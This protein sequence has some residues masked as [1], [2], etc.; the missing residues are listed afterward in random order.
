MYRGAAGAD[1]RKVAQLI[2][3]GKFGEPD[4]SRLELVTE[5]HKEMN[6]DLKEGRSQ[7]TALTRIFALRSFFAWADRSNRELTKDTAVAL[8]SAWTDWLV[9]RTRL[10]PPPD[11]QSR[12][13]GGP[14]DAI[15]I[16]ENSA[17]VQGSAVGMLL[18]C[19][20]GLGGSLIR[21]TRLI[22]LV[23]RKR[24]GI[25][26]IQAE[27]QNLENTMTFG[28]M[29]QDICDQL[30][31]A[32]VKKSVF[33]FQL[34]LR[35]GTAIPIPSGMIRKPLAEH[36]DIGVWHRLI[37]LRIE[38][39]LH[40]FIQQTGM[41]LQ[42]AYNLEL[43]HFSYQSYLDGYVV[44][45]RKARRGG[46]VVFQI[47]KEYRSHLSR[48]LAW[49]RELFPNSKRLFPFLCF[50]GRRE[51]AEFNGSRIREICK[52]FNISYIPP[53][54][55]RCTR[56]N[57][58]LR[59]SA[60]AE[61]TAEMVQHAEET[62]LRVYDR[63]SLQRA[64]AEVIQFWGKADPCIN[65]ELAAGPGGCVGK[66]VAS[67]SIP[68]LAPRPDCQKPS[69]CLWCKSHRDVDSQDYVW[70]LATFRYLKWLELSLSIRRLGQSE[71][72]PASAV[73]DQLTLKLRWF[74]QSSTK[75][76]KWFSE[77]IERIHE[78]NYHP[79]WHATIFALESLA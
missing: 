14:K 77:A 10:K 55:L 44:K 60:D 68:E 38:A 53:R 39:E 8:Y 3:E 64:T 40:M 30:T 13:K 61:L 46:E 57:W 71:E 74:E 25:I 1:R 69:G 36:G 28:H 15:Y 76:R 47:F 22:G 16:A 54:T 34:A 37:N 23:V 9:H 65:M 7:R 41:N 4:F 49:R 19:A 78:G 2:A 45:D 67:A 50:S 48:Y 33:P 43:R 29:L 6:A 58:L 75:R 32:V 26:G 5:L 62:L 56:V 70:L 66:P 12:R 63:P 79:E 51:D 52:Q 35:D 17:H 24:K 27:K 59:R 18:T 72:V 11:R 31:L 21:N 73:I 42:Q 20:L